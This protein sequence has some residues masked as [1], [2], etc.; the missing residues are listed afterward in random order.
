MMQK[1][2]EIHSKLDRLITKV[3]TLEE[4]NRFLGEKLKAK[5]LENEALKSE[6]QKKESDLEA[7]IHRI[8]QISV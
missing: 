6:L 5:E 8:E 3:T 7:I 2:E 4:E 1:S